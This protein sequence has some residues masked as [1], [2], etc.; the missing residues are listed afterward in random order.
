[1][2]VPRF[3]CILVLLLSP[4]TL[5]ASRGD[6]LVHATLLADTTAIQPGKPFRLG[7]LL[8]IDPGWHIYWKNPGDSGLPTRVKLDLPPGFTASD[9]QYPIPKK[10]DLPGDIVNYAYED[11]VMLIVPVTPPK[12]LSTGATADITAHVNWLVCQDVC[13][14]GKASAALSLSTDGSTNGANSELFDTWT[15]RLPDMVAVGQLDQVHSQVTGKHVS[16]T[17][18][19]KVQPASVKWFPEPPADAMFEH[20]QAV[21]KDK[22]TDVAY[23]YQI[24]PSDRIPTPSVIEGL[25]VYT[26][27]DGSEHGLEFPFN[28]VM[29]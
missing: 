29:H 1:M 24:T 23:D 26:S 15:K 8:K 27:A 22:T 7:V 12:E 21:T 13:L 10:L 9:V 19:W 14:P 25:L 20:M 2:P 6:E 11:E 17:F 3:A 4:A 18:H 16:L 28:P 5:L